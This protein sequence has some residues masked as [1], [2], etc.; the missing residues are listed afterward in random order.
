MIEVWKVLWKSNGWLVSGG[1]GSSCGQVYFLDRTNLP[2]YKESKLFAFRTQKEA[3]DWVRKMDFFDRQIW[4]AGTPEIQSAE[5]M[6][7]VAFLSSVSIREF[8]RKMNNNPKTTVPQGT[9]YCDSLDLIEKVWE[10]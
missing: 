6:L 2:R 8:W 5:K 7:N 3:I 1:I 4:R 10:N 9:V